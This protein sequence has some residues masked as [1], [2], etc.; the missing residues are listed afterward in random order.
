[1]TL[2]AATIGRRDP[3]RPARQRRALAAAAG[4]TVGH[5][6]VTAVAAPVNFS[7]RTH[8]GDPPPWPGCSTPSSG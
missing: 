3:T 7:Q 8:T 5:L 4:L 6:L 2:A 1:L